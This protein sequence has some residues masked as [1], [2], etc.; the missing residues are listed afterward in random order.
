MWDWAKGI[1]FKGDG[2]IKMAKDGRA[3]LVLT[4]DATAINPIGYLTWQLVEEIQLL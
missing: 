4:A 2:T 1:E 3:N